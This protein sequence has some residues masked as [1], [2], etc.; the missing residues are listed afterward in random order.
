[1]RILVA[2][3]L[4]IV[5]SACLAQQG[6]YVGGSLGMSTAEYDTAEANAFLASEGIGHTG[7]RADEQDTAWK[8]YIG[9]RFNRNFAV[10]GGVVQ[11]GDISAR[12]TVVS[13][14]GVPVPPGSITDTFTAELGFHASALGILPINER[15]DVFGRLGLYSV[16]VEETIV[17]SGAGGTGVLFGS[18]NSTDILFGVGLQ[19]AFTPNLGARV[20]WERF[21]DIVGDGDV[22]MISLGITYRF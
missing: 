15:M 12:A 17:V 7:V 1:M 22:D 10:E 14:N 5:S 21:T 8:A 18:E 4:A 11:L 13:F 20:E 3:I 16:K 19:Y 2:V 6:F 9:Y